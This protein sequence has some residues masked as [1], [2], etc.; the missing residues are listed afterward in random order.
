MYESLG[1]LQLSLRWLIA[2]LHLLTLPLGLGAVWARSRALSRTRSAAD[3]SSVFVAD[4]LWGLAAFLW[5]A[6]GLL[7]VFA[8]LDKPTG[9]YLHAHVFYAKMG[10][11]LVV[12]LLELRPMITLIRWRGALRRGVAVDTTAAPALARISQIQV[13][14]VVMI[15]FAATALAR[16][17]FF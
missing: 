7:R 11:F 9:Y 15:V 17:F 14:L 16:G 1:G 6:T 2:T 4:N 8:G 5:L 10:L 3:L 13:A 12:V